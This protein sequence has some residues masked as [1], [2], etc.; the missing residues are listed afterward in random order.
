MWQIFNFINIRCQKSTAYFVKQKS[1]VCE[2]ILRKYDSELRTMMSS[3]SIL[4]WN[5]L[6]SWSAAITMATT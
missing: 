5:H 1:H 2:K 4:T 6:Q 3:H